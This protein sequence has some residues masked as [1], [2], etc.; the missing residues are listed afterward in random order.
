M[1]GI[2]ILLGLVLAAGAAAADVT[3]S[4]VDGALCVTGDVE[5]PCTEVPQ[6]PSSVTVGDL[7]C[8]LNVPGNLGCHN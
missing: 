5:L 1:R 6:P 7:T 8:D 3:V 4:Y 2:L